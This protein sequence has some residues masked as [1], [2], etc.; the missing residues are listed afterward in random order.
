MIGERNLKVESICAPKSFSISISYSSFLSVCLAE[1]RTVL[2][3]LGFS[4][5]SERKGI[6]QQYACVGQRNE[7][8]REY[9]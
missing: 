4:S 9:E 8:L 2:S 3:C 7:F 1:P 5:G 6:Q